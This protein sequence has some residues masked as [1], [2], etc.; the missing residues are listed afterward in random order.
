MMRRRTLIASGFLIIAGQSLLPS[1]VGAGQT[2]RCFGEEATIVRGDGDNEILGTTGRDVIVSR[3]GED[4][5]VS[6]QGNDLIC[7]GADADAVD[8]GPGNDKVKGG[9]GSDPNLEGGN[10]GDTIFG[11]TGVDNL[12]AQHDPLSKDGTDQDGNLLIGGAGAD[13]IRSDEG[14]DLARGGGG[15][16]DLR[17]GTG[18]DDLFGNDGDDDLR[19]YDEGMGK[20][21]VNGGSDIEGDGCGVDF[22]DDRIDCEIILKNS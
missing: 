20:D 2:P 21:L 10:G 13:E 14:D 22:E 11:G 17:A 8:A 9:S 18:A 16:D 19:A 5:I 3:G 7:A 6:L 1:P 15:P 4:E 12:Y